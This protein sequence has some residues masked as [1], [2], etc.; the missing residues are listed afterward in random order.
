MYMMMLI[1]LPPVSFLSTVVV[2]A[3][4]ETSTDEIERRDAI[5]SINDNPE[6]YSSALLLSIGLLRD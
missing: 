2:N 3:P 1:L 4:M 5:E 6:G